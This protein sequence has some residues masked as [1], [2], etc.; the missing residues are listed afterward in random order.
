MTR[1]SAPAQGIERLRKKP[2]YDGG[3]ML[4][5]HRGSP[6][7]QP[8]ASV[9]VSLSLTLVVLCS[10]LNRIAF[11]PLDKQVAVREKGFTV[12]YEAPHPTIEYVRTADCSHKLTA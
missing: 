2:P 9:A 11:F 10:P 1:A 12:L 5:A 3:L 4:A 8:R 6:G 7:R